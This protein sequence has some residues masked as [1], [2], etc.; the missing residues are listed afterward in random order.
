MSLLNRGP[1]DAPAFFGQVPLF[2]AQGL[3]QQQKALFK[4]DMDD[5]SDKDFAEIEEIL[6]GSSETLQAI[7]HNMKWYVRGIKA[8]NPGEVS[9]ALKL[10][11]KYLDTLGDKEKDLWIY[12]ISYCNIPP[13]LIDDLHAARRKEYPSRFKGPIPTPGRP[14]TATPG[15]QPGR[16]PVVAPER[17]RAPG[18]P[19]TALPKAPTLLPAVRTP[20]T[21]R[22]I[23]TQPPLPRYTDIATEGGGV[24][25][26]ADLQKQIT[27]YQE[28]LREVYGTPTPT[29]TAGPKPPAGG[30]GVS[31][32]DCPPGQFPAYPGGP[33]RGAVATG[34][35]PAIPGA[36]PAVVNQG[37]LT[38]S[39][40]PA[41]SFAGMGRSFPVMNLK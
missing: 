41:T 11:N 13:A 30:G 15:T 25:Y 3:G 28:K 22:Q 16:V 21:I 2:R 4:G 35:L 33:C 18:I 1:F 34:G 38:T 32:A 36:G 27:S 31:M 8:Q 17:M 39:S 29:P 12:L 7:C 20:M 26:G 6:P 24:S 40:M 37:G 14:A 5:F 23:P 19:T 10:V 9:R